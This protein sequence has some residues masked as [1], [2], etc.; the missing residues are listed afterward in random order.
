MK[1]NMG[2]TDRFIRIMIALGIGLLY[3]LEA[4]TGT[5]GYI[6]LGIAAI[7]LLTS[8]VSFCP[9]YMPFGINTC[10]RK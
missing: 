9:L 8:F 4:I 10:S 6:L 1:K 7:F 3:Y 5:L 2:G